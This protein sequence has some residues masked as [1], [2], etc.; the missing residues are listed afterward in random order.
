MTEAEIRKALA[1]LKARARSTQGDAIVLTPQEATAI[2]EALELALD[3][4]R[5]E[6]S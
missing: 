2:A 4:A 3:R 6:Q 5:D 1:N